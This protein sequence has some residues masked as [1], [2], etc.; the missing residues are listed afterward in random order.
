VNNRVNAQT[1]MC[2]MRTLAD[3]DNAV[4]GYAA[5]HRS[6]GV[7]RRAVCGFLVAF[8]KPVRG[9][10]CRRLRHAHL[11]SAERPAAVNDAGGVC[12]RVA[13]PRLRAERLL[14]AS[15]TCT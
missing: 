13:A 10:E 14:R 11:N 3:H 8:A 5:E 9:S 15:T 2:K 7:H 6:H 1:S 4:E 12:A